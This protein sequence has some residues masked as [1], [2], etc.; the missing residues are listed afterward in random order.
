LHALQELA[1]G[2]ISGSV[3]R[4]LGTKTTTFGSGFLPAGSNTVPTMVVGFA[5]QFLST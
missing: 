3:L 4:S 1:P 5:L 2:T